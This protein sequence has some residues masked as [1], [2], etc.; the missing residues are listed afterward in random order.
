MCLFFWMAACREK[1][2]NK[3]EFQIFGNCQH[4][5]IDREKKALYNK[6]IN[7]WRY[8]PAKGIRIKSDPERLLEGEGR[9]Q[10]ANGG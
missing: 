8:S 6:V 3:N 10:S 9:Y 5:R 7:R 4:W 2:K 1:S